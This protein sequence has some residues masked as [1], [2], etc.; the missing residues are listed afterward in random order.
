MAKA[1]SKKVTIEDVIIPIEEQPYVIPENWCWTSL[2][3]VAEWGGW[4]DTISK[5]SRLL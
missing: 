4:G 1:K 5:K 2:S 3:S